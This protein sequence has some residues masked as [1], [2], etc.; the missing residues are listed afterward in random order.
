MR[1]PSSNLI[2]VNIIKTTLQSNQ[3]TKNDIIVVFLPNQLFYT[4]L[5]SDLFHTLCES[6]TF[7][8]YFRCKVCRQRFVWKHT[9]WF[10]ISNLFEASCDRFNN[11]IDRDAPRIFDYIGGSIFKFFH[12]SR[13]YL[14]EIE[15]YI[16]SVKVQRLSN[17]QNKLN[18][19]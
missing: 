1:Q 10:Y 9:T 12:T 3:W 7:R 4:K 6:T 18:H 16:H 14:T 19:C 11:E 13:W 17:V 2:E 8:M 15:S 5:M